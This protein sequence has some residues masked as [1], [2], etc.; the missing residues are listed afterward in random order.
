MTTIKAI[1]TRYAGCRFRSRLEARW[2]VFFDQ[3]G[4]SWEYEP[5]GYTVSN[6]YLPDF[7]IWGA[8]ELSHP[9]NQN[10]EGLFEV[11]PPP[12]VQRAH[13]WVVEELKPYAG[14]PFPMNHSD[15]HGISLRDFETALPELAKPARLA[16]TRAIWLVGEIRDCPPLLHFSPQPKA[17]EGVPGEVARA[18]PEAT[19]GCNFCMCENWANPNER[20]EMEPYHGQPWIH[21]HSRRMAAAIETARSARFE[22]GENG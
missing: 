10:G 2:A 12:L 11:K 16:L 8:D 5:E 7:Q 4:W 22:H 15:V 9:G 6:G 1:E 13:D 20:V 14:A 21:A 3:L 17:N 19:L 18:D